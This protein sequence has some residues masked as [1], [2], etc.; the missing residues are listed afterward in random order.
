MRLNTAGR[1][2]R[3]ILA[4]LT[5][6]GFGIHLVHYLFVGPANMLV[7]AAP[8]S[9]ALGHLELGHRRV[10]CYMVGRFADPQND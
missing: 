6:C 8:C 1:R 10:P 5:A 9:S 4:N 3:A 7:N 2:T